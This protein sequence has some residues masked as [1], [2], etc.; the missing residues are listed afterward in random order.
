MALSYLS[1]KP[2]AM[3]VVIVVMICVSI[4]LQINIDKHRDSSQIIS[5][6]LYLNSSVLDKVS[7]G[8]RELLADIY[9]LRALQYFGSNTDGIRDSEV[10]YKYFDIMTDLDPKFFNA[11]RFGGTFL[12]EPL[13]TGLGDFEKGV[14][15]FEKGRANNPNSFRIPLEEAFIYFIHD[16]NY[17]K[18]AELFNEASEKPGLPDTLRAS[19]KGMAGSA[20]IKGKRRELAKQI[21]EQIY[22]TT[23]DEGRKAFALKNL[24]ELKTRDIEDKLTL[25]AG[26]YEKKHGGLPGNLTELL[27][28]GYLDRLPKDHSG[29]EFV[30]IPL[31]K[32]FKSKT[33]LKADLEHN[34]RVLNSR[35]LSYKNL[36]GEYPEKIDDLRYFIT[37]ARNEDYP[38]NPFGENYN[39]DP[40]TGKVSYKSDLLD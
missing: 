38:E 40:K 30:L 5:Q 1:K 15:L 9:W 35:A 3:L 19:I 27:N 4:P 31:I 33:L 10:L 28:G 12:A 7:L 13:P 24:N 16:K 2:L 29:G 36:Y 8:Y 39:L 20:L 6:T 23:L 21:W 32:S 18:A 14:K 34:L 11:Y 17:A 25:L 37:H 26:N 22:N